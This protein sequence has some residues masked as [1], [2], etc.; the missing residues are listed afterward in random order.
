MQK[1]FKFE[2][3][4]R[5]QNSPYK[6]LMMNLAM[7]PGFGRGFV[8]WKGTYTDEKFLVDHAYF[9]TNRRGFLYGN[10]IN[11]GEMENKI[12]KLRNVLKPNRFCFDFP[13]EEMITENGMK[14]KIKELEDN[15]KE[16]RAMFKRREAWLQSIKTESTQAPKENAI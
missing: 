16:K 6:N 9:K 5:F 4:I 15:I 13:N 1:R 11:K 7:Y 3:I 8:V 10:R 2:E 12:V 14:Y